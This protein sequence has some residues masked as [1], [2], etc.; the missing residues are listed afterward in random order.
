MNGNNEGGAHLPH[1]VRS[2]FGANNSREPN[3]FGSEDDLR[4]PDPAEG[5]RSYYDGGLH[6]WQDPECDGGHA[7]PGVRGHCTD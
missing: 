3:G 5:V 6:G 1:P 2:A 4:R 7:C